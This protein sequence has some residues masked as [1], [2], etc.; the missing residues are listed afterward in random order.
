M[1]FEQT[2]RREAPKGGREGF[3]ADTENKRVAF[4]EDAAKKYLEEDVVTVE[5]VENILE[6][7]DFKEVRNIFAEHARH[8]GVPDEKLNFVWPDRFFVLSDEHASSTFLYDPFAN[9]VV[10]S[11]SLFRSQLESKQ[12]DENIAQYFLFGLF[13]ELAHITAEN[14]LQITDEKQGEHSKM[15]NYADVG[16]ICRSGFNKI[17]VSDRAASFVMFEEAITQAVAT[18]V[19][20]EYLRRRPLD[21][22]DNRISST[23]YD[24]FCK[25]GVERKM[26][27][28]LAGQMRH[29]RAA[30]GFFERLS[31]HVAKE[32]GVPKDIANRAFIA[33]HYSGSDLTPELRELIDGIV[34]QGFIE[35]LAG[36]QTKS[37]FEHIA[38]TYK[39]APISDS[40][41]KK[42]LRFFGFALESN[43]KNR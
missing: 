34:G 37:D 13:H 28:V 40:M 27:R 7:V 30:Q 20:R 23:K 32:C 2:P 3:D 5:W 22:F 1:K 11:G 10:I 15:L 4:L 39:F 31:E 26:P 25:S 8:A 12:D 36:A 35:R 19:G 9:A 38:R 41:S 14:R 16:I 21:V 17:N 33:A 29:F 43:E 6:K 42:V 24:E 18:E